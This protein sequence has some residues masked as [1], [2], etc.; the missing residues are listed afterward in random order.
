MAVANERML[1][2]PI[3]SAYLIMSEYPRQGTQSAERPESGH[4]RPAGTV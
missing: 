2:H 3:I 4:L 1:D